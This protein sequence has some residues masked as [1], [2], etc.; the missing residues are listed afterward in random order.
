MVR[1]GFR[2]MAN[3]LRRT[4]YGDPFERQ[5]FEEIIASNVWTIPVA[6]IA[7]GFLFRSEI[8]GLIED[9]TGKTPKCVELI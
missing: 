7:T 2:R 3:G 4:I 9:L 6:G 1:S 8:E 5:G